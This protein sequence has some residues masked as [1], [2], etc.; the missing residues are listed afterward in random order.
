MTRSVLTLRAG[1]DRPAKPEQANA[2]W[3]AQSRPDWAISARPD[4]PAGPTIIRQTRRTGH[5]LAHVRHGVPDHRDRMSAAQRSAADMVDALL[6]ARKRAR[7]YGK[8]QKT[9]REQYVIADENVFHVFDI[10]D[11]TAGRLPRP[12]IRAA[13]KRARM[14]RR[15]HVPRIDW[16]PE[17]G[18]RVISTCAV[19]PVPLG[20]P[21]GMREGDA[22]GARRYTAAHAAG[23]GMSADPAGPTVWS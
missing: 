4:N 14:L 18:K 6:P 9:A 12:I 13:K 15:A 17:Y 1:K 10:A 16:R 11:G 2:S 20:R 8:R 22:T 21:A 5:Q 7:D 19:S 23:R 3:L